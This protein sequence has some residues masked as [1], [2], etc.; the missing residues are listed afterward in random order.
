MSEH[1]PE[2]VCKCWRCDEARYE[3]KRN[4][5]YLKMHYLGYD[6]WLIEQLTES[7]RD[8]QA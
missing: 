5:D 7:M 2:S 4:A 8:G 6:R 3:A 1:T